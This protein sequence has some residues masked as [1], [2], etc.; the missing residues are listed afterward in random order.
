MISKFLD[1]PGGGLVLLVE[2]VE[3][4]DKKQSVVVARGG[5]GRGGDR[6]LDVGEGGRRRQSLSRA[7]A[8]N[9]RARMIEV[10]CVRVLV[11]VFVACR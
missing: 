9:R 5:V 10:Y 6:G 8:S 11:C 7:S 1:G 2:E 3:K 4:G